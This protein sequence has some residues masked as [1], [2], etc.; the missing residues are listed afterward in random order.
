MINTT[1]KPPALLMQSLKF[2]CRSSHIQPMILW[3]EDHYKEHPLLEV[4]LFEFEVR[5]NRK[6]YYFGA[7]FSFAASFI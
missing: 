1:C 2:L 4:P 3:G 5:L 7:T 6:Y